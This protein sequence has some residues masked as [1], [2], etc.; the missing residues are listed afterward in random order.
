M[1][2][3]QGGRQQVSGFAK[4][5]YNR[6]LEGLIVGF[7]GFDMVRFIGFCRGLSG[8]IGFYEV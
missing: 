6:I 3:H 4:G 2:G 5:L 7:I 8:C 1:A